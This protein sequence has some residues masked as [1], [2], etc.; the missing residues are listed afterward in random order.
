MHNYAVFGWVQESLSEIEKDSPYN[1]TV[2]YLKGAEQ[3]GVDAQLTLNVMIR[4]G[5]AGQ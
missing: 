3:V 2:G 5:S 1:L 4:R